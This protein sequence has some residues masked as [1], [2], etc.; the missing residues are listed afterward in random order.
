MSQS[1]P[2]I[3][4][5]IVS[6]VIFEEV[7]SLWQQLGLMAGKSALVVTESDINDIYPE[8]DNKTPQEAFSLLLSPVLNALLRG[9]N[10]ADTDTYQ[11]VLSWDH[12]EIESWIEQNLE[13]LQQIP[14]ISNYLKLKILSN[15]LSLLNY[16]FMQ[17]LNLFEQNN[18][19]KKHFLTDKGSAATALQ[20]QIAQEKL[21]NQ[22]IAQI[23]QSLDLSVILETAVRE[24]RNF[25]QVD[26]LVIYQ[27]AYENQPRTRQ[28]KNQKSWGK[29]TY[30]S[31]L[32]KAIPS[33]LN[34]KAE[35]DCFTHVARYQEKYRQGIIVDIE[36]VESAYSSS[37][38]LIDFLQQYWI[39]AKLIAPIVID[40]ELWGLLIAHQCFKK[41]QWLNHEKDFLGKIGEHL[42]VAIYQAQLYSQVQQQ[43]NNFEQRVIERTQA[44]RDTLLAAQAA[45]QSK[46]EFLG[47]MSHELRTPLTC[48]IGLSGTLLHWSNNS[49]SL[50]VEKQKQYLET[51][52]DSGKH[53]LQLINEILEFSQLEAGKTVL[54]IQEFSLKQLS[55]Q[56]CRVL[57]EEANK[58][59]IHL[60]LDLRVDPEND[61]FWA[62]PEKLQQILYQLI[63]N[64]IKFTPSDG[65]VTLRIWRENNQ[66]IFQVEDT[67]IGIAENQLPLLFETFQQLENYR[68]RTYSGTGL[69]L[70]LTKQLVELHQGTIEVE[71]MIQQGSVFTVVIPSQYDNYFKTAPHPKKQE[72]PSVSNQG[73]IL[74]EQDEE[75]ATLICELLTTANY[76][77]I[78]LLEVANSLKTIEVLH[79]ALVILSQD[80]LATSQFAQQLKRS[81]MTKSIK[82]LLI[83]Q[84]MSAPHWEQLAQQGIDDYILQPIDPNLLLKRVNTLSDDSN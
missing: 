46:N 34:L 15:D 70:A 51:I 1:P 72:T 54:T 76:Q 78:W 9:Q 39:Q 42:A 57:R 35:D 66:A 56:V 61:I 4:R 6:S 23:R 21:L 50:P 53:L 47:N 18:D 49:T 2:L 25:L 19:E 17:L 73:V 31:R 36:D 77:V 12:D 64:A 59:S 27:F 80:T 28:K 82:T 37:F 33:M 67:G 16:L 58:Q 52:Q 43:K 7:R 83:T 10:I 30:E 65:E 69:G 13:K 14:N 11:L 45:N 22:M 60:S 75:L 20:K 26:R 29:V 3:L 74:I 68:H 84:Q 44:L 63:S 71:S 48:I 79:P 24:V 38:C 41:R 81:P 5:R 8:K 55:Y 62:D 40:G 32:S